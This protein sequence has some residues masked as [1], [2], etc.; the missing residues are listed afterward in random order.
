MSYWCRN[1]DVYT[2]ELI[3]SDNQRLSSQLLDILR[4]VDT[5]QPQLP[6]V[7]S[8]FL[9][10]SKFARFGEFLSIAFKVRKKSGNLPIALL[11]RPGNVY[12]FELRVVGT[13]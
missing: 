4:P 6:K 1:N 13:N 3:S 10:N 7:S 9:F 8:I 2:V 5:L 12:L 11:F